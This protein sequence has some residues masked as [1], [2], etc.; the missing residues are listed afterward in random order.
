[1]CAHVATRELRHTVLV[2]GAGA[3]LA[4]AIHH[5]P[6]RDGDHPP[7]DR[8]FF[9]RAHR[10][11]ARGG[12]FTDSARL[13]RKIVSR[14]GELGQT[15]LCGSTPPI[16]LEEHLGRLFFELNTA[17][18]EDNIEGYYDLLRL[19]NSELITTTNWMVGRDG[20]IRDLIETELEDARVSVI[21][22]NHD[23]LIENALSRASM[24]RNA[25]IWCLKHGYGLADAMEPIANVDPTY[26]E[27]CPGH[28]DRHVRVLKMHGSCNWVYRTRNQYPS[29]QVA[30]GHRTVY[31]WTNK[32]LSQST[33]VRS[34]VGRG[35]SS[36]Y[37]WPLII[38]PVYEKHSYIQGE[39]K[40]VWDSGRA[41]LEAADKVVFWGYSFPRADLH[42]R[43]FFSAL[44]QEN[45]ALK[46]PIL[47][48]P[49]PTVH[50]ELWAILQPAQVAHYRNVR[51]YLADVAAPAARRNLQLPLAS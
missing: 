17:A 2:L 27:K 26:E 13:L 20:V 36:W 46:R 47:I 34:E 7:L 9:E 39:L 3:S 38:P 50:D 14:A 30:K 12:P 5:R 44:A 10:R 6:R 31:L 15:D 23:L 48:N 11:V 33:H 25:G 49:D 42:A 22:F 4:E 21:T 35:R 51:S 45:D 1:M 8:T 43:Y 41:A 24:G 18:T 16:S 32:K 19:Y 28:R 29:P 40:H 37:M